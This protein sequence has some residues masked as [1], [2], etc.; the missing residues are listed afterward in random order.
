[1]IRLLAD[2]PLGQ[3][4]GSGKFLPTEAGNI[5]GGVGSGTGGSQIERILTMAVGF[6][7]VVG[8][9]TFLIFFLIGGITWI[10]AAGDTKKVEDAKKYMTNG[11]IGIIIIVAAYA[12]IWIVGEVLGLKILNPADTIDKFLPGGLSD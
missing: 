9:L 7:T 3:I 11:A 1:M 4:K 12:V 8:G 2:V 5:A 6:L 10:T